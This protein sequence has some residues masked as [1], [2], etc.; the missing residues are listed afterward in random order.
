M[1]GIGYGGPKVASTV[2]ATRGP[3]QKDWSLT[4]ARTEI[5]LNVGGVALFLSQDECESLIEVLKDA[6]DHLRSPETARA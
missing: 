4:S 6:R 1:Y 3:L 2:S 5:H